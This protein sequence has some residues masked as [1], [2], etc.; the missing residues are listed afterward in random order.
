MTNTSSYETLQQRVLHG[1][2]GAPSIDRTG[3]VHE[4][5]AD[6]HT[7]DPEPKPEWVRACAALGY[8]IETTAELLDVSIEEIE[9]LA[10]SELEQMV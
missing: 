1:D 5:L 9:V 4:R 2:N 3:W 6:Q 10:A 8:S 7:I